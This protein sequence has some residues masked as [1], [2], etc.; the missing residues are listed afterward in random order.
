MLGHIANPKIL[1]NISSAID[2]LI[3]TMLL[4]SNFSFRQA[5]EKGIWKV[6]NPIEIEGGGCLN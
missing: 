4:N 2:H 5:Q 3:N 6:M 1:I